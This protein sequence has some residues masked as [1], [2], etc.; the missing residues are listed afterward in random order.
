MNQSQICTVNSVHQSEVTHV[1]FT[2]CFLVDD[3]QPNPIYCPVYVHMSRPSIISRLLFLI[4][5]AMQIYYTT[6]AVFA[7]CSSN[8]PGFIFNPL[9]GTHNTTSC[10]CHLTPQILITIERIF[11]T[12]LPFRR[13]N[14]FLS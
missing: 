1:S 7:H 9:L 11:L 14:E 13:E 2:P 5:G 12:F 6:A 4:S 8:K 10:Q 3:P